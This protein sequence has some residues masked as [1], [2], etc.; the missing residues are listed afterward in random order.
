MRQ[1]KTKEQL[2]QLL[3]DLVHVPS[4]SGSK[5]EIAFPDMLI[6]KLLTLNYFQQHRSFIG[7]H[8]TDDGRYFVTALYKKK[9]PTTKTIVLMSHFDVVDIN[10]YGKWQNIAFSPTKLT[11]TFYAQKEQLPKNVQHDLTTGNWLFGRGTMD[12]KCGLA[13]HMAML[14]QAIYGGFEGNILLLT[15]PDEEVNS[16]GMRAAMPK[17]LQLAQEHNLEYMTMLNSEP[18]FSRYPGD[19]S[20]YI[21]TGTIGKVLA[22]FLCYG[23]E[24]HAG[25]PFAGLNANWLVSLINAE[26]ELNPSFC[27]QVEEEVTPPPTNLMQYALQAGYSTQ[28]PNRAITLFNLFMLEKSM[29]EIV[30]QLQQAAEKVAAQVETAYRARAEQYVQLQPFTIESPSIRV[31]TYEQLKNYAVEQYSLNLVEELEHEAL[32]TEGDDRQ[33]TIAI[34]DKLS[35]LCNE[36]SPMIVLFF[37]PPFYPAV[38]SRN[39]SLIQKVTDELQQYAANYAINLKKQNYFA[40]I[41]DLSYTALQYTEGAI[42]AYTNNTPLWQNGYQIPIEAMQKL[43]IPV[44]NIGPIGKDAHKWTERLDI[45]YAFEQLPKLL[46]FS[47]TKLL[48]N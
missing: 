44:L 9:E 6:K 12:M 13:L 26:M 1:W 7:K 33:R 17:L 36:C 30:E 4:I 25:E 31:W 29:E 20:N 14:E 18:V 43:N 21:Y 45:D 46:T 24:T 39:H 32:Q 22:G 48:Q 37:A 34:V 38:S 42:T 3:C 16:V 11:E 23:K 40:G 35:K 15:V 8:P 27:E 28:I 41:C 10:D 2:L 5:D 47:I 19:D